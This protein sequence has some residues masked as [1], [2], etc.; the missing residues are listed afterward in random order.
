M[1]L[2]Q[3]NQK[4]LN[5]VR[6]ELLI[7]EN[8]TCP[9]TKIKLTTQTGVVDHKHKR[10]K[11]QI[12]GEDGVG[13]IRSVLDRYANAWEGKVT[14]SF[15]RLGLHNYDLSISDMLRNLADYLE[16]EPTNYI[17][18]TEKEKEPILKKSVYN[19]LV[20]LLKSDGKKIPSYP[21]SGKIT[22]DIK[23][24][25]EKYFLEN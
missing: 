8:F 1:E 23:I 21:K 3:I 6:E 18:P 14:N 4:D 7:K 5:K 22:K 15:I 11:N 19:K 13:L 17:H 9:I 16:R 25:L 24:L 12:I 20:K 2:I 10:Y